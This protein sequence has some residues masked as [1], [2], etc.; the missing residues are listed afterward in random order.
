MT[1]H[2]LGGAGDAAAQTSHP[3]FRWGTRVVAAVVGL[4]VLALCAGFIYQQISVAIDD[5][6]FPAT[7]V[8]I[9]VAGRKVRLDCRGKGLPIVVLEAGMGAS[10]DVWSW[11]QSDVSPFTT[12]CFYDRAGLGYST[13]ASG[14]RDAETQ[15][16][17]LRQVL[18]AAGLKTPVV[19]AAHSYGGLI[20]R[21]FAQRHPSDAAGL[22]L[23]DSSHED[24]MERFPPPVGKA[25]KELLDGFATA[26]MLNAIGL[27]RLLGVTRGMAA[28]LPPDAAAR[29]QARYSR[30]D[31]MATAAREAAAWET[32]AS[33][34]RR[35]T[36][37][38]ALPMTVMMAGGW[39]AGIRPSWNELQHELAAKSSDSRFV[40]VAGA[41]HA[42]MNQDRRFARQ[43]AEEIRR[44][45]ERMRR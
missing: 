35:V 29:V 5:V 19:I 38:G 1:R 4:S 7:G 17:E 14:S 21:I 13:P 42:G 10:G 32:S 43:V 31:H 22:V 20:A 44:M 8:M 12:T 45:V 16:E 15:A 9:D 2:S 3:L 24:M 6:E 25:A 27:P 28:G 30:V 41:D 11:V 40:V 34:A 36:N 37:L 33:A 23:V 18:A 39:P 26:R